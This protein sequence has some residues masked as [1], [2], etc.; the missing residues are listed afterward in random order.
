LLGI[1]LALLVGVA[2]VVVL[3]AGAVGSKSLGA[4]L[5]KRRREKQGAKNAEQERRRLDEKC[6][7]CGEPVDPNVDVFERGNWWHR[8]CWREIV[9]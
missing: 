6:I 1:D 8:R 3:A 2:A 7:E 5:E 9:D 4:R